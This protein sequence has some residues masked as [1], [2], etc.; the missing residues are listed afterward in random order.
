[1]DA[2]REFFRWNEEVI[3]R[4]RKEQ[5][6]LMIT[7]ADRAARPPPEVRR[8]VAQLTDEIPDDAKELSMGGYLVITSA[9]V[10]GAVTALQWM[11]R[12]KWITTQVGSMADAIHRAFIDLDKAGHRRPRGLDPNAYEPARKLG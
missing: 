5:G 11:T 1:M 8:L 12:E 10:R 4:G 2:V 9:L 7:D 3:E 6:Y